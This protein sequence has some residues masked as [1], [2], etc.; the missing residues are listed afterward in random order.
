M[1]TIIVNGKEYSYSYD[2]NWNQVTVVECFGGHRLET[3]QLFEGETIE[4][5]AEEAIKSY[6]LN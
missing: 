2:S 4:G 5:A 6:L 1:E 3:T